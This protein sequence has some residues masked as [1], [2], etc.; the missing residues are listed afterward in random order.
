MSET[1]EDGGIAKPSPPQTM[2]SLTAPGGRR[3]NDDHVCG[4]RNDAE[5]GSA[6]PSRK[7]PAVAATK[8]RASDDTRSRVEDET[9]QPERDQNSSRETLQSRAAK[10]LSCSAPRL[11]LLSARSRPPAS[12]HRSSAAGEAAQK[13]CSPRALPRS[14]SSRLAARSFVRSHIHTR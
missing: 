5:R 10:L 9:R 8:R 12:P 4:L 3:T 1:N 2:N 7:T 14:E 11:F 13:T 6:G